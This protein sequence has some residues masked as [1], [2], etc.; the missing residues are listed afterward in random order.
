MKPTTAA[1]VTALHQTTV[2]ELR[3]EYL[4]V[5]GE[6]TR[7]RH[8]EFL[9]KQIA[10]AARELLGEGSRVLALQAAVAEEVLH[11]VRDDRLDDLEVELHD[12]ADLADLGRLALHQP[13]ALDPRVEE[14]HRVADGPRLGL[15]E[16]LHALG[17]HGLVLAKVT[18][19]HI[20]HRFGQHRVDL[21]SGPPAS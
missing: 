15:D 19:L 7:S 3:A 21:A 6:E 13:L 11:D 4:A 2:P 9:W 12:A 14:A 5:F 16:R 17:L 20:G 1:R 18:A 8:K 10:D